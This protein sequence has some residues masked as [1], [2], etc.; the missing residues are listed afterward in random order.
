MARELEKIQMEFG[1]ASITEIKFNP[2]SRDDIPKILRGLQHIYV[3]PSLREAIFKL[4]EEKL[5]PSV[6]KS[7][8]RPGMV[9]WKILVLGVLGSVANII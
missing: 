5:L 1:Q 8:G 4:L 2:K 7:I 6:D 3:L 9:L